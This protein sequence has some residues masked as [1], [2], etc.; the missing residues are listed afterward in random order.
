MKKKKPDLSL[1]R[2]C[3]EEYTVYECP[4]CKKEI[5]GACK[6]CHNEVVHDIIKPQFMTPQFGGGPPAKA[7]DDAGPWQSNAI[8]D[9]EDG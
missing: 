7:E 9:M 6:A 4:P 3:D 2:H 1:C 8:R 5:R